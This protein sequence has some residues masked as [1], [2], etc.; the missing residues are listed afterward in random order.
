MPRFGRKPLEVENGVTPNG[1]PAEPPG[2]ADKVA[3]RGAYTVDEHLLS[4][5]EVAAR[6]GTAV[7]W[8]SPVNSK[9]LTSD[10][11]K[12]LREQHGLN[13]LTPPKEK[14]EIVKF[15]L[16]FTNPLMALLVVAGSLTY[17]AYALQSPRD[18]NNLILATALIVVVTLTC[19]M[20]YFQERSASNVMASLK[21]MMPA[22]CT[23][24]RD[25]KPTKVEAHDLVPGDLVTLRLGD[26][27]P[28]DI[29]IIE[30]F[31]LKVEC[32]SLTGESDLVAA[33][34]ERHHDAAAEAGNLVFMSSL[35]MNGE[36][37]G[38]VIRT[39]DNT[40]I[41]KIATLASGTSTHRS[42]LQV[43]VHRLVWFVGI[44]AFTMGMLLFAIGLGRRM[45]P[46][47]AFVNG[48]I[49][50]IVANVPEG[51][52]ATVTSLLT[53]TALRL[54]DRRVLIKR[55]DIIEN[56]GVATIIAS[57]KTGTLTQ[58][59]MSVGNV[60]ANQE[61]HDG[62][63]F[64][65]PPQA[66]EPVLERASRLAKLSRMSRRSA[67]GALSRL[68]K[69]LA[70]T[71]YRP[72]RAAVENPASDVTSPAGLTP[73]ASNASLRRTSLTDMAASMALGRVSR[74]RGDGTFDVTTHGAAV[75]LA[76]LKEG[77][78]AGPAGAGVG[79]SSGAKA[80]IAPLAMQCPSSVE[81]VS[82][83]ASS[84]L[85]Q[86]LTV[87]TVC[88]K[89]KY[90]DASAAGAG[91][92]AVAV[93]T[94]RVD[95]NDRKML[96]DATDCGLLRYCDRRIP[97]HILRRAYRIIFD[98]PFNSANKW[99]ITV[100]QCP[101]DPAKNVIMMKGAPEIVLT[102]C[103]HHMHNRTEKPID[104]EF[105]SSMMGAYESCG[106]M[107]ER[108]IG[109]AYKIVPAQRHDDYRAADESALSSGLVFLGLISLVDPPREGVLE[110]VDRCRNAGIR[111]AMVTGDH[112]LTAEAIAR[113]VGIVTL[114]TPRE[115]AAQDGL[116]I[117]SV[118]LSDERVGAVVVTGTQ[119]REL[120]TEEEWDQ[121]LIKPEIVF[122]RTSPQQKL[123]IVEN[124]QRLG[125]V[126]AV[127]GD[128]VNDA[129]ALK[130]AQIGVAM[131]KGGSDVAREAADIVLMDDQFPSIVNAIEEGRTIYDNLKKTI[132]YTLTH[133]T[134][135]VVPLFLNLVLNMPLGL[136]GL[137]ILSIDL[138]TEQGPA[139]SLAYEGAES[140]VMDRPPRDLAEDRL[141]DGP[142]IRYA[143]LIA[144]MWQGVLCMLSYFT[145]FWWH[146][147]PLAWI[148]N[149][150]NTH[151]TAAAPPFEGWKCVNGADGKQQCQTLTGDIQERIYWESQ[152]A[153]YCTL[154][155]CQF[156]HIFMCK[157]RQVSIF[158][159]GIFR[160]PITLF[161]VAISLATILVVT[162]VPFLQPIFT[163]FTLNGVAWLPQLGFLGFG[164]LWTE[165]SKRAVRRDPQSWWA[166]R[167][168][169]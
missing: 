51:L 67:G 143:Y 25:G 128:G 31:D 108:V 50:V 9:G 155:M 122:A 37:R 111:V 71:S 73:Y 52:P 127:T 74:P 43:E 130:R 120:K 56:L 132:A 140:N 20:S 1:A 98:I 75:H 13:R 87:A 18:R 114:Q 125:E 109:F 118:P 104:E 26:R 167:M 163:T 93:P 24:T 15:L 3:E 30:S 101:G 92:V 90:D 8:P 53:L 165:L 89:S 14:S 110:A 164:L 124:L 47:S 168:Q 38:I 70:S 40:M 78:G 64:Q 121:I 19:T 48:F 149:T 86:L 117:G 131:G 4:P 123:Q 32:S 81:A 27:I 41:G 36:G 62:S 58:N 59:R 69:G 169:W 82:W 138:L 60:W 66:P 35:A 99:A 16:Q 22:Q 94:M 21:A 162:Y 145:V 126:V 105:K 54:R 154:V 156:W 102:K 146:G 147:V 159:H 61:L 5:Q 72:G 97:S 116:P 11:V 79:S 17:M 150:G 100:T 42:T 23:V 158:R 139:I 12:R 141:I 84:T 34:V 28:A 29:R 95:P 113:K 133:A 160:N 7:D 39:G 65:P 137:L 77:D 88:N 153:W 83:D 152:S 49:L 10:Q 85:T 157:T 166:R 151:W 91:S 80:P 106:F 107:G 44:L 55:T 144:G 135:E 119:I 136:S 63:H 57:D 148:Y 2:E 6:F 33:T 161:G 45:N 115:V 76:T 112:P 142:L 68:S 96:G 46:L 129:P 134:P 103:T